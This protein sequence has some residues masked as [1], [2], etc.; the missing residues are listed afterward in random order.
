M[1]RP[2]IYVG[3]SLGSFGLLL[4]SLSLSSQ[5]VDDDGFSSQERAVIRTLSP[6]PD[7]PV[8]TT[9]KYRNSRAAALLGQKLFW[10]SERRA[11][12]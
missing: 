11:T 6:L 9:D 1:R 5:T 10:A 8:D 2:T 7:L 12:E 3:L 4:A